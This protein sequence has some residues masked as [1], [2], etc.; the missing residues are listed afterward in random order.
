MSDAY[1][2]SQL[3]YSRARIFLDCLKTCM[4]PDHERTFHRILA[5]ISGLGVDFQSFA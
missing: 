1:P 5:L 4:H 3:V 2:E